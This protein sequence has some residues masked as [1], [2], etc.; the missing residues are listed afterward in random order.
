MSSCSTHTCLFALQ[1][2]HCVQSHEV[3][4]HF[5]LV[6]HFINTDL[7]ETEVQVDVKESYLRM[8]RTGQIVRLIYVRVDLQRALAKRPS[9]WWLRPCLHVDCG[10]K[11]DHN[12]RLMKGHNFVLSSF[13]VKTCL[14]N[15]TDMQQ[16]RHTEKLI[17]IQTLLYG[18]SLAEVYKTN[19]TLSL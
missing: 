7:E 10:L 13:S 1:I 11:F 14:G 4:Q 19:N 12:H 2:K 8:Q 6:I 9:R 5:L 3:C 16:Q 17:A 15:A 18:R